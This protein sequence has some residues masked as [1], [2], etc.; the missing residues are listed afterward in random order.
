VI[1][2]VFI[3]PPT[4][5]GQTWVRESRCQ[6]LDIWGAPFPPLTLGYCAGQV[7]STAKT[8]IVDS[9]IEGFDLQATIDRVA[10]F[11]ARIAI[12]STAT[13]TIASDA[14]WFVPALKEALPNIRVALI[15]SH[16]TALPRETL[17]AYP[18]VD[19]VIIGEPELVCRELIECQQNLAPRLETV[20][21]LAYRGSEGV[22]VNDP[23]P[24]YADLDE[25][26]LPH[27]T[28]VDF[29]RYRLPVYN[30]PFS[31]VSYARGCPYQCTFCTTRG[32]YGTRPRYRSAQAIVEELRWYVENE[33]V[34]DFLF[35]SEALTIDADRLDSFLTALESS[36]LHRKIRWVCNSRVDLP[37]Y[38]VFDRMKSLGCWQI[39]FGVEFGSDRVLKLA[40][41]GGQ[42][43][44]DRAR[45]ACQ[46][47]AQAGMVVDGHF[48][49]G[50]PGETET[51]I[52]ATID[53]S[54]EL[55]LTFAHFYAATPFPG[56]KLY[57]EL[58]GQGTLEQIEW[59]RVHQGSAAL[60]QLA[61]P[62]ARIQSMLALAYRRFYL[63]PSV[64]LRVLG[65]VDGPRSLGAI[66]SAGG[67]FIANFVFSR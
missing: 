58:R 34:R 6:Q 53:L 61:L 23:R 25:L 56:S 57:D 1:E 40:G 5:T 10:G 39:A 66:V 65:L 15:G 41:K 11:G 18:F 3:N 47:A 9:A 35:W 45:R 13:P 14:D 38:D 51:E 30:R 8:L 21:G 67:R 12:V 20:A 31:L 16:V 46:A 43:S 54:C 4:K 55:P 48:I 62:A 32:F 24:N 60:E 42:A 33:N 17:E 28:G 27:W 26:A 2:V 36:G 52:E 64:W 37:S 44:V 50:Y 22:V 59:E 63:R 7:A 29:A 19:F 49:L